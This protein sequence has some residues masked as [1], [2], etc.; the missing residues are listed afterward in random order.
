MQLIFA[1]LFFIPLG[2]FVL[3]ILASVFMET[4]KLKAQQRFDAFAR[5]VG[6]PAMLMFMI[7]FLGTQT[8]M[9]MYPKGREQTSPLSRTFVDA[10]QFAALEARLTNLENAA[11]TPELTEKLR[12]VG[13]DSRIDSLERLLVSE[14]ERLVSLPLMK[15]DIQAVRDESLAQREAQRSMSALIQE[16]ANQNRW[17]IG[18]LAMGVIG[19]LANVFLKKSEKEKQTEGNGATPRP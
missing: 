17:S 5:K 2:F 19:I 18:V 14:P 13:V 12:L 9:F 4:F 15:R 6:A 8:M 3:F 11:K 1:L 16:S 10:Q 7:G